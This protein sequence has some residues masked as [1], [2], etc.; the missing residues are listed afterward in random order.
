MTAPFEE[1]MLTNEKIKE[2]WLAALNVLVKQLKEWTRPQQGATCPCCTPVCEIIETVVEL[3]EE[4]I[5]KY[6]APMLYLKM[7]NMLIELKP[8]GRFAIGAI[9]RVDMTNNGQGYSLLY[10][11][12]KGWLCMENRQPL[13]KSLFLE[14]LT[15]L[16]QKQPDSRLH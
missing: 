3:E 4:H 10:S 5:G 6:S 7:K 13:T 11:S 2:D 9:G 8:A 15:K 1:G 12:G 14:L 16:S